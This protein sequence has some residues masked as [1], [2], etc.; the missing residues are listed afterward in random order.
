MLGATAR[1]VQQCSNHRQT[2]HC[3]T[4]QQWHTR[5]LTA[6]CRN[7]AG[8]RGCRRRDAFPG[9]RGRQA[10]RGAVAGPPGT[11]FKI[12]RHQ[13]SLPL[14]AKWEC[15][16]SPPWQRP[17][18]HR[19]RLRPWRR[20]SPAAPPRSCPRPGWPLLFLDRA[21]GAPDSRPWPRGRVTCRGGRGDAPVASAAAPPP[22]NP[23]LPAPLRRL[24]RALGFFLF[25]QFQLE[26]GRLPPAAPR[27]PLAGDR[28][29]GFLR[30]ATATAAFAVP[31]SGLAF[32]FGPRW[33]RVGRSFVN[34]RGH[35]FGQFLLSAALGEA[36]PAPGGPQDLDGHP[37][38][39]ACDRPGPP[40]GRR[41]GGSR[42]VAAVRGGGQRRNAQGAGH[43]VPIGG[44]PAGPGCGRP[45]RRR[46][47]SSAG[48]SW[49][50][51]PARSVPVGNPPGRAR[52]PR[53]MPRRPSDCDRF[54]HVCGV[55]GFSAKVWFNERNE[56]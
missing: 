31:V 37:P 48:S 28:D 47:L 1:L 36:R 34:P 30:A 46:A 15:C 45:R 49:A 3:W 24:Q 27:T 54:G 18:R 13:N 43:L 10:R 16:E 26:V 7:G 38:S 9:S 40:H 14:P 56:V 6:V 4:S 12:R 11:R 53:V 2:Q 23:A 22:R 51:R 32:R 29:P 41:C 35:F 17:R 42:G 19:L 50:R 44:W 5:P 33:G 55:P 8:N 20:A 39:P 52:P 25:G 21:P